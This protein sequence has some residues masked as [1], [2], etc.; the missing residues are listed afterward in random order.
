MGKAG[1]AGWRIIGELSPET[2]KDLTFR[3][4]FIDRRS[5]V[6]FADYVTKDV[7]TGA[8]HI[9]PGHGEEDYVTG[10]E[11]GLDVYS[12]VN[13]KGELTQ[14]MPYFGG[15]NVFDANAI[16]IEKLKEMGALSSRRRS[17]T[18]TR[19]AGGARGRSYSGR[20]SSGSSRWRQRPPKE[21]PCS[22]RHGRVDTRVGQGAHL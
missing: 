17:S 8:V 13:E 6:V 19:T 11:Y 12:P 2:L 15:L 9:A 18:P 7:G 3:H 20:R 22:D 10:L 16:I 14:D 5:V 21:G 4:P 1:I